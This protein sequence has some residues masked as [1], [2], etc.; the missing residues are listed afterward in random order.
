MSNHFAVALKDEKF[1]SGPIVSPNPGPMLAKA[2]AAP[3]KEV[4][5]SNPV[6]ERRIAKIPSDAK[7]TT[8]NVNTEFKISSLICR[9]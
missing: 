1:P 5:K 7:K 4:I 9:P 3:D 2:A 6:S 8:K